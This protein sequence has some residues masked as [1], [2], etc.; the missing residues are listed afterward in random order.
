MYTGQLTA[1]RDSRRGFHSVFGCLRAPGQ[2]VAST[3][4]ERLFFYDEYSGTVCICACL[5]F[6]WVKSISQKR[7]R[8]FYKGC[9]WNFYKSVTALSQAAPTQCLPFGVLIIII[10]LI[11]L[12]NVHTCAL[13]L[14]PCKHSM[15]ALSVCDFKVPFLAPVKTVE[16]CCSLELWF[17]WL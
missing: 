16:P 7:Q 11:C 4:T 13:I 3:D 14:V 8:R 9:P 2:C 12:M 10:L 5:N 17:G 1:L 6:K 15:T